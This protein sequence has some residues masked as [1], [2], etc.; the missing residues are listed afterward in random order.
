MQNKS[1][2]VIVVSYDAFSKDN[3]ESAASKPNLAKLIERGASTNLL[4]SVYPTL[5]YVIHSSYVTGVYPDRHGVFHNN[6]FQ[7]FVPENEQNWHWFRSDIQAPTVYEAAREKG[8]TTAGLLWPVSGK[9][10]INFNIP[11]IKAIKNENQALKILKSGSKLFTLQMEMKY[12]K[13]RQGIQQPYLDDFTTLCAVDTIKKKKPNLLLMHL[14]DLDDTKHLHGTI[15]PHIEEVIERMDRRIG[16]LVQAT[17][18]ADIYEETTFIIVGDHSQL[19]VQYKVYLN[20]ILY[21]EGLIYEKNGKWHWRAYV[22]G[23]GGA[24]YLHVQQDDTEAEQIALT[25]LQDAARKESFGIEAILGTQELQEFHIA[26]TFRYMIEAKEGYA[27]EDDHLQEA[28][29]DLHALGKKYATHGYSPNKPDYTSNL[30]ISG[31]GVIAGSHIGEACVVDIGP[32]IAHILD[33]DF[34][35]TDGRAL[36]EIFKR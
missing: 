10:D 23:A 19:D 15:G 24:A 27:F 28:I 32:T 12:G 14:I 31:N 6:P 21:E 20:R 5:T 13:V 17:K 25:I 1:N 35:N 2:Y 36:T 7:P 8:L 30:I 9:A 22:Q 34:R 3:W 26:S 18:D 29:I 33:L 16:E 11:E 4:K